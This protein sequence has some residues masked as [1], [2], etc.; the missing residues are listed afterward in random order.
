MRLEPREG[1]AGLETL[2]LPLTPGDHRSS[3]NNRQ[4][5]LRTL[6]LTHLE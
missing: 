5:V 4:Q 1:F 6:G 2:T 3:R